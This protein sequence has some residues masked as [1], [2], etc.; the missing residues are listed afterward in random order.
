VQL[1][2]VPSK[3]QDLQAVLD[4]NTVNEG[5]PFFSEFVADNYYMTTSTWNGL[6]P[7]LRKNYTWDKDALVTVENG[8]WN[9]PYGAIYH[10]NFVLD[11]LKTISI[12]PAEQVDY[13]LIRGSA[14]FFRA[15]LH[16]SLVQLYCRPY[17]AT[18]N[19]D[20]GLVVRTTSDIHEPVIRSTVQQT[21]DQIIKDLKEA[22]ELL[23]VTSVVNTRPNKAAA[24][25][26]L[27]RVYLSMRDYVNAGIQANNALTHNNTL[28]DFN[29]LTPVGNPSPSNP[30]TNPEILCLSLHTLSTV[31]GGNRAI[32][33][34]V[35][36]RS[37]EANDLRKTVYYFTSAGSP[38]WKGSYY[39]ISSN[40]IFDGIATDEL[41]LIRAESN[42]RA[43]NVS[44]AMNDLNTLLSKRYKTGTFTD[45]T[46]TDAADAL[47]QV[48]AERR[49][50]LAFR[51]LRWSD[52]RRFNLEG[53]NITLK[54]VINNTEYTLPPND[55]RW[56]LLIPEVEI[57]RSGIQQNPR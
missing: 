34:S 15:L 55:L 9:T 12:S 43:G 22:I 31:F 28:M 57:S 42:A 51:G 50:E 35:L 49:K 13:N 40:S 54:R 26:L 52:L 30:L 18:A 41:F 29:G 27:A 25:G 20:L 33:D 6:N 1:L 46:A 56:V 7:D 3:L 23:P 53:A 45:L 11:I 21:Y 36:Y 2:H 48:L 5:T 39:S 47:A 16:H 38:F 8:S 32:V 10:T 37:Y 17:S 19:T 44:G 4:N 14:L 24:Q